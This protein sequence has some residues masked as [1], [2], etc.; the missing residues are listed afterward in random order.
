MDALLETMTKGVNDATEEFVDN[1]IESMQRAAEF[2]VSDPEVVL[3]S[4]AFL[5]YVRLFCCQLFVK[6]S[7]SFS[8]D[9]RSVNY[10]HLFLHRVVELGRP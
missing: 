5:G 1:V 10:P 2:A 3:L 4:Y 8:L 9:L 6:Y 7:S